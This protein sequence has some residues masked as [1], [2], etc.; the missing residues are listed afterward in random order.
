[1]DDDYDDIP[2]QHQRPFGSGLHKKAIAF[3]PASGDGQLNSTN[4]AIS[5]AK[6]RQ[7]VADLY[8]SMVLPTDTKSRASTGQSA[9]SAS[10]ATETTV[11]VCQVCNLPLTSL[12]PSDLSAD[13]AGA[14]T[15]H[16]SSFAHQVCLP[17]SHPPSALDR[18]RMGLAY[19]SSRGW[20]PDG[21][22]G[23]G[24]AQQGI[25]YPLK[26]K[27]KEDRLGLGLAVPKNLPPPRAKEKTLHAGQ[28]RK[29][30]ASEKRR[31]DRIRRQLFERGQDLEKYLGPGA[32]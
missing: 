22:R 30:V 17:H 5:A 1:E 15:A 23:L 6:P 18:S 13:D 20:D 29:L 16:E 14:L 26:P 7:D 2:L 12:V 32:A 8:L 9:G 25:Q 21:R 11:Q 19:L 27:P 24:A 4:S 28:V 3:V 10:P 31:G